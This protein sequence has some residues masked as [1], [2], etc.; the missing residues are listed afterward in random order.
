MKI[1]GLPTAVG[2]VSCV[3]LAASA[4]AQTPPSGS[5]NTNM[6]LSQAECEAEWKRLK[7]GNEA[8]LSQAQA[9]GY[10]RDFKSV[11]ANADGKLSATEW[12]NGCESGSVSGS[13][14]TGAG[15]GTSGDA[16][17]AGSGQT[18]KTY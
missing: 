1:W 2:I 11:D 15:S 6:K 7:T 8:S 13:A 9:K 14:S 4:L 10:V 18:P 16:A 3:T 17:P 5:A 12:M